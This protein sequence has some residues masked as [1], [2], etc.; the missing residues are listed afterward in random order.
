MFVCLFIF[1]CLVFL[2]LQPASHRST[3]RFKINVDPELLV[4]TNLAHFSSWNILLQ[5]E[6]QWEFYWALHYDDPNDHVIFVNILILSRLCLCDSWPMSLLLALV[7]RGTGGDEES[8]WFRAA[9]LSFGWGTSHNMWS[10]TLYIHGNWKCIHTFFFF[11][12]WLFLHIIIIQRTITEVC[13]MTRQLLD[14]PLCVENVE[15]FPILLVWEWLW[16]NMNSRRT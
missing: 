13:W 12:I 10:F 6:L 2:L 9:S 5:F 15:P 14:D 16:I 8:Q 4:K 11:Y 3:N 7:M 1:K